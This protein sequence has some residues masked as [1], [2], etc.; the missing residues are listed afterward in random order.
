MTAN[1]YLFVRC[2]SERSPLVAG[3]RFRSSV[4]RSDPAPAGEELRGRS[5]VLVKSRSWASRA[6]ILILGMMTTTT[7]TVVR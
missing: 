6:A 4:P 3:A 2:L 7:T 1:M 5:S